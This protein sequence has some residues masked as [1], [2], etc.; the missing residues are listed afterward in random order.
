M[1]AVWNW[2]VFAASALGF[3]RFGWVAVRVQ[4]W[5]DATVSS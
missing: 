1:E 5:K 4:A 3:A 2:F